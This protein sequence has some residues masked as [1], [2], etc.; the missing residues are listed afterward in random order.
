MSD[1]ETAEVQRCQAREFQNGVQCEDVAEEYITYAPGRFDRDPETWYYCG[2]HAD[3]FAE[4]CATDVIDRG[5]L[6]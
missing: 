5:E 3:S 1:R 2:D 4:K 6:D